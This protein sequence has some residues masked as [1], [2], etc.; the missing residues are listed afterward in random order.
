M[1]FSSHGCGHG[2][3]DLYVNY[4]TPKEEQLIKEFLTKN[5]IYSWN[6]FYDKVEKK[7]AIEIP[8]GE[9][10]K[11]DLSKFVSNNL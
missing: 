6:Y 2:L 5:N 8:F 10:W 4:E 7:Q 1:K 11:N 9:G 3:N